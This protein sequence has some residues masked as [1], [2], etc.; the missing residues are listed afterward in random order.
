MSRAI[1]VRNLTIG[2]GRPKIC[3]SIMGSNTEQILMQAEAANQ[4]ECDLAELRCD[5]FEDVLDKE[6]TK[7]MLRKLKRT[8]QKPLIFTLRTKEEG[9][10]NSID[11]DHYR[12]LISMVA[13][14]SLADIIDIEASGIR[15][16]KSFVSQIKDTGAYVIIS[17]HDF[18][19]TPS[20]D[21]I[22]Y[23]FMS[24]EKMG[25][26]IVKA[27][28][29]PSSREDVLNLVNAAEEKTRDMSS[30]P[31]IAISM[32]KMGMITR[33][34]GE[35]LESAITF[36]A[37]SKSSAPGQI[38][39]HDMKTILDLI[40]N[41]YRKVILVGMIGAGKTAVA[42]TLSNS[43]G[44]KKIDLNAYIEGKE[45]T[46]IADMAD[47]D[48]ELFLDKE[49]KYLRKV[50]EKDYNVISAGAGIALRK[51]NIDLIKDNG[52]IVFLKASPETIAERLK[53]DQSRK[54]LADVMDLN[55]L[56]ELMKN[57]SDIYESVA[58]L[59]IITDNK[60]TEE[61]SKEI[62]ETLGFTV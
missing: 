15:G 23:N 49:T 44:L 14:N 36:A 7:S 54:L 57:T 37:L 48:M 38:D 34:M 4:A 47:R 26:D 8:L 46:S 53:N 45:M 39:V 43:Y 17:K 21:E 13:D 58:D 28:Y 60:T 25:A 10:R 61:I 5:F 30:C 41:N 2:R 24:M 59:K 22:L 18:T 3:V 20:E 9:G 62:V 27:A 16:D 32:G 29:M 12:Q 42:N 55:T 11:P 31:V 33:I 40:H 19:G 52:I 1:R 6:R 56:S 35:F 51:E 50:L